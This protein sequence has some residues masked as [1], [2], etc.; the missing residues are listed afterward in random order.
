[1]G[2]SNSTSTSV[3][4][5]RELDRTCQRIEG[6]AAGIRR[7]IAQRGQTDADDWEEVIVKDDSA[8][9]VAPFGMRPTLSVMAYMAQSSAHEPRQSAYAR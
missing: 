2:T 8:D 3:F 6:G 1:M 5:A 7:F 9:G 4:I